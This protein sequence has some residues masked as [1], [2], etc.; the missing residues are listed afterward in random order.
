M[1]ILPKFLYAFQTLPLRH[2][3]GWIRHMQVELSS[4]IWNGRKPKM[5]HLV[6]TLPPEA[7]GQGIPD[8]QLYYYAAQLRYLVKWHRPESEKHWVFQ[9]QV[10]AAT[11]LQGIPF[12]RKKHRPPNL[13]ASHITH[14]ILH[15]WD[16]TNKKY[17]L[18]T[19][20]S[21][22]TPLFDN[23]DFSP[24]THRSLFARWRSTECQAVGHFFDVD[25]VIP[26]TQLKTDYGLTESERLPYLQIRHWVLHPKVRPQAQ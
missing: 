18:T 24:G 4:Y 13:Y 15:T 14:T 22:L 1:T 21:P 6:S 20:P 3:A 23:P 10:V 7:E 16:L 5:K 26:F 9:D 17:G 11:P 25:S 2:P 19:F 8:L 12:L